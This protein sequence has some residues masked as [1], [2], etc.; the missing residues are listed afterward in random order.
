MTLKTITCVVMGPVKSGTTLMISLMDSHKDLSLFPMEVKFLTH[1]FERLSY[2][3]PT[4]TDLNEFFL[5]ESKI[6]LMN[7]NLK[8]RADIMNS[9]RINFSGFNYSVF[10]DEMGHAAIRTKEVEIRGAELFQKFM[11]DIHETLDALCGKNGR[12]VIV[13]KEGNHGAKYLNQI[14]DIYPR[15]KF[16]V[17]VRD[18]RDIFASF[19]AIAEKKKA[20]LES[21]SFKE[22][23]TP[24]RFING[25]KGKNIYAYNELAK[26]YKGSENFC[27]VRYEDLT[28]NTAR[29]MTVVAKFLGVKFTNELISPTNLGNRWGGNA[30]SLIGFEKVESNRT[31]KWRK[32]LESSERR[33]IEFFCYGYLEASSYDLPMVRPPKYRV[34]LDIF[35]TEV[36]EVRVS[37]LTSIR[38]LY[39]LF[40]KAILLINACSACLFRIDLL[41][42]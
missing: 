18:P 23:I 3:Q 37:D 36:R 29:E 1:W 12:K 9:G 22:K 16:I 32:E 4:Y 40:K 31:E 25:N 19:K 26:K 11:L 30:S 39:Y 13:S 41:G 20:G 42:R 14:R 7:N 2:K 17:I 24:C 27:F 10:K 15:S 6:R 21:P 33:I 5:K 34:I 28:S 38:G 8:D 35:L